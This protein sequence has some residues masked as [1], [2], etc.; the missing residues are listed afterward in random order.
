MRESSCKGGRTESSNGLEHRDRQSLKLPDAGTKF[1]V[2]EFLDL[3]PNF[4]CISMAY[5]APIMPFRASKE[6]AFVQN[7]GLLPFD[8]C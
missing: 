4:G 1:A 2:L 7:A 8:L 3:E 6:H 5:T